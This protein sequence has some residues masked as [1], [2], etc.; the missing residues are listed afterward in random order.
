MAKK[1]RRPKLFY[2]FDAVR[3]SD[4]TLRVIYPDGCSRFGFAEH[5]FGGD[6]YAD[7]DCS[8]TR[9]SDVPCWAKP[10]ASAEEQLALMVAYDVEHG[11]ETVYLGEL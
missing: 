3:S 5:P 2:K 8:S 7:L 9:D 6:F 1:R 11:H 10:G 4:D